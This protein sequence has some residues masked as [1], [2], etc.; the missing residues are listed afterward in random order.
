MGWGAQMI[1]ADL[2][3]DLDLVVANGHL[4]DYS[5]RGVAYRMPTQ[6]FRNLGQGRFAEMPARTLG[7]YFERLVLGR[8]IAR[9]DWNRDGGED[10]CVTHVGDPFALLSNSTDEVGNALRIELRGVRS[11][12]DA[13]G[14]TLQI[15]AG[16]RVLV[17]QLTAGDGF[18]ASN[19]RQLII[20]LGSAARADAVT[21]R[22]PA[23]QEQTFPDL[24]AGVEWML[25]EGRSLPVRLPVP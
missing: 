23:G 10:F 19:G 6:C 5:A 11:S 22:W 25:I 4:D 15:A 21:V 14:A 24:S 7:P 8:S 3:G 13:I 1:D 16:D 12:R 17:R 2:D 20:G 18:E 9:C